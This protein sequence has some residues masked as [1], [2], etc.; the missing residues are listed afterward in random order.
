MA[1]DLDL[2]DTLIGD[3]RLAWRC[4]EAHDLYEGVRAVLIDRDRAPKWQPPRVKDVSET[5]VDAYF[6]PLGTDELALPTRARMQAF[7]S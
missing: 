5:M 4:L 6:S 2:R 7:A 1:R 3:F